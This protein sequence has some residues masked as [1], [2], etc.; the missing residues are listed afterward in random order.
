MS[1]NNFSYITKFECF[2]MPIKVIIVKVFKLI[3]VKNYKILILNWIF[4]SVS[5]SNQ[6]SDNFYKFRIVKVF[7]RDYFKQEY[8]F[9]YLFFLFL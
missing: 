5:K 6:I 1:K 4:K 7:E 9:L 2:K 8:L 3:T